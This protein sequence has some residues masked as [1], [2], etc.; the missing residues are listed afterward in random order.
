MNN[1][2]EFVEFS[3]ENANPHL[4]RKRKYFMNHHSLLGW[5]LG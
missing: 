2:S 5:L 4:Y 1:P 3:A